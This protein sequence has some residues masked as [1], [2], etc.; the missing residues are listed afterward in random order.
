MNARYTQETKY[1]NEFLML[2][3]ALITLQFF[4]TLHFP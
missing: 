3:D 2:Q 1:F 4:I